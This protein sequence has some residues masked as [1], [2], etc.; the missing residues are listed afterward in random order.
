MKA[1]RVQEFGEPQVLE[2]QD[3]PDPV[4]GAGQVVVKIH[5]IG[6][7]PVDTYI[8]RGIYGPRSFPFTLGNDAAGVIETV[9]PDAGEWRAGDRVY[10]ATTLTGA[11]AEKAL[12]PASGV[13]PLPEHVSFEQG[14][15]VGVPYATAHRALFHRARP[16]V[17]ETLLVHGASGGVGIASVQFARAFGL[18]VIGT[19]G[20]DEGRELVRHEGAHYVYDHHTPDYLDRLKAEVTGG[21]GV[22]IILEMLANVNLGKD[23]PILAPSGR[24]IVI[25]SRGPV[26]VDARNTMAKNSDIRG[27]SFGGITQEEVAGIHRAIVVGLENRTLRPIVGKR[28]SLADAPRAHVEVIEGKSHGKIVLIP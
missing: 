14:A 3:V 18:L 21:R 12:C 10:V 17:G 9:G 23:L 16:R 28:F 20:S 24:V 26:Q 1:I 2:L 8:R 6:I 4:P 25:G 19:A 7:N 27:V 22:D 15:A 5:A 13:H 11:Y